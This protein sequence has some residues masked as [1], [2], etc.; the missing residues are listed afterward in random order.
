MATTVVNL[1]REKYDIYIGRAGMGQDGYFGN[2]FKILNGNRGSTKEQFIQYFNDRILND[3]V[4][5]LRIET[6]LRNNILG[7]FCK[8]PH[9]EVWCHG[10]VYVEYLD[11]L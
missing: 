6:E 7:C 1:Y 3:P 2:P 4:F 10:D 9:K 8:Q 5:R 11:N